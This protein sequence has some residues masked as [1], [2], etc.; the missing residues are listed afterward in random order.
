MLSPSKNNKLKELDVYKG[1]EELPDSKS[2][3]GLGYEPEHVIDVAMVAQNERGFFWYLARSFRRYAAI[4]NHVTE[5]KFNSVR[6]AR[7]DDLLNHLYGGNCEIAYPDGGSTLNSCRSCKVV[8]RA[9]HPRERTR[10]L[11]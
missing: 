1:L 4:R 5:S 6:N 7:A 8:L 10:A 3:E 9:L 2:S 11:P